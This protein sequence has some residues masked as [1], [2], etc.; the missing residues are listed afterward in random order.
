MGNLSNLRNRNKS[1]GWLRGRKF[2]FH[3]ET[4][5]LNGMYIIPKLA[6][7]FLQAAGDDHVSC[8]G[9]NVFKLKGN[10]ESIFTDSVRSDNVC[11]AGNGSFFVRHGYDQLD[12]MIAGRFFSKKRQYP[13]AAQI[14]SGADHFPG[15]RFRL[16]GTG[17]ITGFDGYVDRYPEVIAQHFRGDGFPRCEAQAAFLYNPVKSRYQVDSQAIVF[18]SQIAVGADIK[19]VGF[20]GMGRENKLQAGKFFFYK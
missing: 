15:T 4:D 12:V 18:D 20:P 3:D 17:N 11:Q 7:L 8:F 9:G 14:K 13:T 19:I 16:L 10:L 1:G 6:A 2:P 5:A